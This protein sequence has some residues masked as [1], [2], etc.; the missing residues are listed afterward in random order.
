MG[1]FLGA[2]IHHLKTTPEA[3]DETAKA[4]VDHILVPWVAIQKCLQSFLLFFSKFCKAPV[5]SIVDSM[6]STIWE[7]TKGCN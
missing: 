1:Y 6:T 7:R 5:D 3:A 4:K 2:Q